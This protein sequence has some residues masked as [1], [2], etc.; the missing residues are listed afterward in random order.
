MKYVVIKSFRDAKKFT[1][2]YPIGHEIEQDDNFTEK[3]IA[4][5]LNQGLIEKVEEEEA[6]KPK[7][8]KAKEEVNT[9]QLPPVGTPPNLE[10]MKAAAEAE[11]KEP[12]TLLTDA[13]KE[14]LKQELN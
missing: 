4:S 8:K 7:G 1:T 6:P 14:A 12:E 13:E 2:K 11:A 10:L 9:V 3:R 5:L